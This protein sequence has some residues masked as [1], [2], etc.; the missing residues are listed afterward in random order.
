MNTFP[1]G[2]I[3]VK[4]VYTIAQWQHWNIRYLVSPP[5][6]TPHPSLIETVSCRYPVPQQVR[7]VELQDC[8]F[9]TLENAIMHHLYIL[10]SRNVT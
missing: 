10:I 6:S 9:V 4:I 8:I 7:K 5:S 3:Q 2:Y 1:K